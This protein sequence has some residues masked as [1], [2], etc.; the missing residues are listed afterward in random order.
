MTAKRHII[1]QPRRLRGDRRLTSDST[2]GSARDMLGSM[3]MPSGK[4]SMWAA[5][6]ALAVVFAIVVALSV[7]RSTDGSDG[8][9]VSV[10]GDSYTEGTAIGGLGNSNWT[11]LVSSRLGKSYRFFVHAAGG[12]GYIKRGDRGRRFADL[13]TDLSTESPDLVIVFGSRNDAKSTQALALAAGDLYAEIRALAP[14]AKILVVSPPWANAP[15][16]AQILEIRDILQQQ[17]TLAGASFLDGSSNCWFCQ[18]PELIGRDGVHP[19]DAGQK[20]MAKEMLPAI[21]RALR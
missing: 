7:S 21:E 6:L 14:N 2:R 9:T 19:T 10:I 15:P 13:A 1:F 4:S 8:G 17:A 18:Q 12:S 11:H 16:P 5:A 3:R 20:V